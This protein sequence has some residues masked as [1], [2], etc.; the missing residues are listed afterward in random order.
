VDYTAVPLTTLNFA[1]GETSKAVNVAIK[2]DTLDESNE[3][4]FVNLSQPTRATIADGRGVGTIV[5]NEGAIT[6]GPSTFVSA[7]DARFLEGNV[8]TSNLSFTLVRTGNTS[9]ASS[10]KYQTLPA[11]A[12]SGVDFTAV[13]LTTVNFA[14]GETT[15]TVTVTGVITGDTVPEAHES[16]LVRLSAP[17]GM[18]IADDTGT[19]TITDNDAGTPASFVISDAQV[20]ERDAGQRN[21]AFLV[22]RLGHTGEP[23]SVS[24]ATATATAPFM[25]AATAGVD[26]TSVPLTALNFAA[27]E[28]L[29]LVLVSVNGDTAVE[30][31]EYFFVD[32]SAPG[33]AAVSDNRGVSTIVEDSGG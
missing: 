3:H 22:T 28:T 29:K 27:G 31:D 11:S 9:G 24:Y 21:A 4:F 18:V 33:R 32:L 8:G 1:A 13:P 10:V 20:L 25:P 12:T 2:G 16:F 14:A 30:G 7:G 23:V 6:P 15:K 17:S 26:Y 19:M 5:D